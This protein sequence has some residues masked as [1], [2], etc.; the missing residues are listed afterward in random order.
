MYNC[1]KIVFHCNKFT[2]E[3][4]LLKM[5]LYKTYSNHDNQPCLS[6][7]TISDKSAL[8]KDTGR[9][10]ITPVPIAEM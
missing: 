8:I 5:M 7:C 3:S 9:T 10:R 1:Y 4:C 2:S 6:L